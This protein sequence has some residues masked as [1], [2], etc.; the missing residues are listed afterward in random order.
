MNNWPTCSCTAPPPFTWPS[1]STPTSVDP[2]PSNGLPQSLVIDLLVG[3]GHNYAQKV[4]LKST[5]AALDTPY[6]FE[7]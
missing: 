6:S 2:P 5:V 7:D 1:D 4:E 3:E